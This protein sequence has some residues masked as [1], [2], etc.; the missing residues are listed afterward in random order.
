[1][2]TCFR[3]YSYSYRQ[4]M[5]W[6]RNLLEV[7]DFEVSVF[8]SPDLRPPADVVH[9]EIEKADCVV[10]LLGPDFA[11]GSPS[12]HPAMWP[13]EEAV[14]A[15]GRRKPIAMIV[16]PG[17]AIPDLSE[18]QTPPRFD[19]RDPASF[20]ENVH[21]VVKHLLDTKRRLQSP[22]GGMPYYFPAAVLRYR[23]GRSHDSIEEYVYHEVV[24]REPWG[25]VHHAIDTGLD[26]TSS[27]VIRLINR[28]EVE[29][30]AVV[31]AA[32][33]AARV[34]LLQ[35]TNHSQPYYVVIDPP[36]PA[37][38]RIGY[39]RLFILENFFPLSSSDLRARAEESGFPTL[40]RQDSSTF[41]GQTFDV[42]GEMEQLTVSYCFP[43]NV[44][45]RSWRAVVVVTNSGEIHAQESTRVDSPESLT[46]TVQADSGDTI[47]ELTVRRPLMGH[48][49]VLL[50]EPF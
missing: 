17:T 36:L 13:Y 25:V 49:Y 31:G 29:I 16:H 11:G 46:K 39:R 5:E 30:E 44:R 15:N 20:A 45:I 1:M 3:S 23:I 32:T 43:S 12:L 42:H 50:Y 19:F 35:P 48:S 28:D 9:T 14:Y 18:A 10:V 27:A 2:T 6:V 38:G 22:T 26:R 24:A 34:D 33:Y 21:H 47:I 7:L 37:G 4:A 40:F 8:D 41:Y